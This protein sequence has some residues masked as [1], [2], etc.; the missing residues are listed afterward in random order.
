MSTATQPTPSRL[1]DT[2]QQIITF[3]D[4]FAKLPSSPPS[5]YFDLE[6]INLSRHGT[7]SI[8]Q[9]F[10]VPQ[11][12]VYLLDV[13][14]LGAQAFQTPG[15]DGKTTLQAILESADIAKVFFDVRRD[16]DALYAHFG[17]R[18]AGIQDLQLMELRTR[19]GSWR[20]LHG[21]TRCIEEHAGLSPS[22]RQAWKVV[23]QRGIYRF[24][25][26][27]GGSYEV[28]NERPLP[29]DIRAYC[30]QDVQFMPRLWD[31]YRLKLDTHGSAM[32]AQATRDRVTESQ[33]QTFMAN[34]EHMALGPWA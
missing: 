17:V 33:S 26:K 25:P 14:T 9:V 20:L 13:H 28:F 27:V 7:I 24:D 15:T 6:G 30:V 16:S 19:Q 11:N 29:A 21:L 2:A 3:M 31:F 23:K 5:F 1:V 22:D 18:L 12:C 10:A 34:G 32:V 4:G 8:V